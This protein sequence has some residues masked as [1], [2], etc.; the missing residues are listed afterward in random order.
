MRS[1]EPEWVNITALGDEYETHQDVH[2]PEAADMLTRFRHRSII[3]SGPG[4]F[5]DAGMLDGAP[6]TE[7]YMGLPPARPAHGVDQ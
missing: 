6:G 7:W 2:A 1:W 5:R 4:P 3:L